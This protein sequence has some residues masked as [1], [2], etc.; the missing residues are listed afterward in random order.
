MATQT[1][2]QEVEELPASI[3]GAAG[4]GEEATVLVWL[5]GGGRID[6]RSP[7]KKYTLLM[8][9][10]GQGHWRLVEL[11]LRRGASVDLQ[12][13]AGVTALMFAAAEGHLAIARRLLRDGGA[14]ADLLDEAGRTA[15][16]VAE[17]KRKAAVAMAGLFGGQSS[18]ANV[19][20]AV[21]VA[22][23][24]AKRGESGVI[25]TLLPDSGERYF[26]TRLWDA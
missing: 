10:S 7:G 18:G 2:I 12:A 8:I 19:W 20:T 3:V 24:L 14:R 15:L 9:A 17:R 26:S 1:K 11:L 22:R 23:D 13:H 21:R 16:D 6:A 25:V 4:F 5:D